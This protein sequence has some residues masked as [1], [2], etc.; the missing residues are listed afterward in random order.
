MKAIDIRKVLETV[1]TAF[2]PREGQRHSFTIG[3]DGRVCLTLMLGRMF[4]MMVSDDHDF[5]DVGAIV[6]EIKALIGQFAGAERQLQVMRGAIERELGRSQIGS[7]LK[8][9]EL[10]VRCGVCPASRRQFLLALSEVM[11][12]PDFNYEQ[13]QMFLTTKQT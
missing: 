2:P 5:E 4:P 7:G 9:E 1:T 10:E 8:I 12:R 3:P 13:G 6:E 11:K